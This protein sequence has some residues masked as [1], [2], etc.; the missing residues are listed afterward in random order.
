MSSKTAASATIDPTDKSIPP[1][2]KTNVIP[3][4][5]IL[6]ILTCFTISSI[7]LTVKKALDKHDHKI[8]NAIKTNTIPNFET[9]P[10]IF[11]FFTFLSSTF[12]YLIIFYCSPTITDI[13]FSCVASATSIS[14][15]ISPFLITKTLSQIPSNSGISEDIIMIAFPSLASF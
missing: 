8:T 13:I 6:Y 15:A 2:I 4:H 10:G 3:T 1:V 5:K 7:L 14:P 12:I 9:K 11:N